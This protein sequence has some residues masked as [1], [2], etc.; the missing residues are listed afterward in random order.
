[1]IDVYYWMTPNGR[2]VTMFLRDAGLGYRSSR[3]TSAS[4]IS[5][6]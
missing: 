1:M 3:S 5:Q 4:G 2:K 6:E